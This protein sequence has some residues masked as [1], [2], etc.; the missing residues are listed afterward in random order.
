MVSPELAL[1]EPRAGDPRA[2]RCWCIEAQ[3]A[4]H[5]I[6]EG[7]NQLWL[8][9]EG[10][11]DQEIFLQIGVPVIDRLKDYRPTMALI[12]PGL[13]T[14]DAPFELPAGC[15]IE[16][17]PTTEVAEPRYFEEHFTGTDSWILRDVTVKLPES[18]VYFA[19]AYSPDGKAGKLW[20]SIGQK[21]D[22][23]L[24]DLGQMR[25][26]TRKVRAFHE[27]PGT[28]PR[29]QKVAAGGLAGITA[30]IIWLIVGLLGR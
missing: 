6:A 12:G 10:Q 2:Y 21:E 30:G 14:G 15:G 20:V 11:K 17:F 4:R 5:E 28:W 27:V 26:W 22:F 7:R 9:F 18:R 13:P 29:L 19:V 3:T 24:G 25:E 23:G 8:T 16:A 1:S